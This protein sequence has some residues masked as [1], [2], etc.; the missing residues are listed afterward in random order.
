MGF[1]LRLVLQVGPSEHNLKGGLPHDF[2]MSGM[3]SGF[4]CPLRW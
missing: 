4:G 2:R 3:V 1:G